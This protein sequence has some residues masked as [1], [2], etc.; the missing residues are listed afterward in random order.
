MGQRADV[1][2]TQKR[3]H[4]KALDLDVLTF[5]APAS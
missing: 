2:E 1:G 4:A 5:F 3:N